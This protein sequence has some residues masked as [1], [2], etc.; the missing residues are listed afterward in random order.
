MARPVSDAADAQQSTQETFEAYL[1]R[2]DRSKAG[3][4]GYPYKLRAQLARVTSDLERNPNDKSPGSWAVSL[5]ISTT[6]LNFFSY[7]KASQGQDGVNRLAQFLKVTPDVVIDR[8]K[9]LVPRIRAGVAQ[10]RERGID[11]QVEV[12]V[13][14]YLAEAQKAV[15]RWRAISTATTQDVTL[16]DSMPGESGSQGR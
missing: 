6:A 13:N 11:P 7:R 15:A 1:R 12:T 14:P 9:R 16:R 4:E 10:Y 2:K 5:G 8:M 3:S